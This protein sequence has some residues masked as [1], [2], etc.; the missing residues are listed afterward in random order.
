MI[1]KQI[2]QIFMKCCKDEEDLRST[3]FRGSGGK[4]GCYGNE[5]KGY[6]LTR[7]SHK[8]PWNKPWNKPL[9]PSIVCRKKDE[10]ISFIEA[11]I[12]NFGSKKVLEELRKNE[13]FNSLEKR[14]GSP[15]KYKK[16][17]V[18]KTTISFEFNTHDPEAMKKA[19]SLGMDILSR[20]EEAIK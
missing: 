2:R 6:F 8:V 18:I 1:N 13:K 20:M 16:N 15:F 11:E 5:E 10:N 4:K 12:S 9:I 14:I 17:G 19:I 7:K 3:K